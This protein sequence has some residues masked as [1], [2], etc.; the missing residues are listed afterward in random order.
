ML[1]G[2]AVGRPD[3]KLKTACAGPFMNVGYDCR[4][5]SAKRVHCLGRCRFGLQMPQA[6][7]LQD[8]QVSESLNCNRVWLQGQ[9]DVVHDISCT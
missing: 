3:R 9:F 7:N 6:T 8:P 1:R 2:Q 5:E 4:Q